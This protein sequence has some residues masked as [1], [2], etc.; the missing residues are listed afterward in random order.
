MARELPTK[1]P[2]SGVLMPERTR[3]GVAY[4]PPVD[5]LE[6]DEELI[7]YADMPGLEPEK[8]D[9]RFENGELT[10]HGRV[11]EPDADRDYLF[12]EYGVGDYVRT[13][14]VYEDVDA[15]KIHAEY[16]DGVLTV[17]L[18]KVAEAKPRRIPVKAG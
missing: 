10:V 17:H 5:I 16:R 7:I 3:G 4:T 11:D 1:V 15:E 18:P 8:I 2:T 12:R 14:V 6:T 9:I 13:F